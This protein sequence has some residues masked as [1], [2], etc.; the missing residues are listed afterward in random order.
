MFIELSILRILTLVVALMLYFQL[1]KSKMK[2]YKINAKTVSYIYLSIALINCISKSWIIET[3]LFFVE[4]I[5]LIMIY[6]ENKNY[7]E[8][9]NQ[10]KDDEKI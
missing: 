8:N 2:I 4:I 9:E 6:R 10:T 5:L 1:R 7:S 3:A